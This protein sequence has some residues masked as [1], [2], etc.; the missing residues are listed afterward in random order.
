MISIS[1]EH[2]RQSVHVV[3]VILTKI[4]EGSL[5]ADLQACESKRDRLWVRFPFREIKYLTFSFL[6][7]GVEANGGV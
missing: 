2:I 3:N 7:S 4:T 6:R 5:G 1:G